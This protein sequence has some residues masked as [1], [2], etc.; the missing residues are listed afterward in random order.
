MPRGQK[1]KLRVREKHRLARLE[2]QSTEGAQA[3]AAAARESASSVSP[4]SEGRSQ[5]V[6]AAETPSTPRASHK[7]TIVAATC[8]ESDKDANSQD[9]QSSRS[10]EAVEALKRDPL[11]TKVVL[12]VQ[13]LMQKY[14]T[15]EP[16]T[17][18]DMIKHV[19]KQHRHHFNEILKRTS[20]HM[21][22]AF[23]VD[24]KEVDPIRHCY[25]LVN[26]LETTFNGLINDE[27]T[28]PKTGL[29]MIVLGVI[30]MN[31]NCAREEDIWKVLN[32]MGV[33]AHKYHFIY[34]D[35]KKTLT[36]DL[37][38]QKYLEYCQ[39]AGSD[40]PC[41]EFLWGARAHAETSK[42]MVL[43][44][45]ARLHN[46]VPDAFPSCYEEALQDEEE[47]AQ[48]RAAAKAEASARIAARASTRAKAL[49]S[50]PSQP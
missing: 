5:N 4:P 10:S 48:A 40:P 11:K 31:G 7:T 30:F 47:R 8:A 21:E 32:I 28:M 6:P 12:L 13:Y 27:E 14:Q 24:L 33:Y 49:T 29:L 26:K 2:S 9:K 3:T 44:F 1:S 16:F 20:E 17:K 42:M 36:K 41:Y 38:Q 18:A 19:I 45:L 22:L 15:K 43:E 23:G 46:T 34:G 25:A 39:V 35:P 37:V 50:N